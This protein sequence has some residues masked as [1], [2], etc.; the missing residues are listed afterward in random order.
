MIVTDLLF[1]LLPYKFS[2]HIKVDICFS[3]LFSIYIS[4]T[5]KRQ[6]LIFKLKKKI[7]INKVERKLFIIV[8]IEKKWK[9]PFFLFL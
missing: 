1:F 9:F 6:E 4:G 2:T 3:Y 8:L 5:Y 7:V